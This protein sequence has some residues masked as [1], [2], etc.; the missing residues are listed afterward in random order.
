MSSVLRVSFGTL[1]ALM[2]FGAMLNARCSVKLV[3]GVLAQ[4][5]KY[6][7]LERMRTES[8]TGLITILRKESSLA[9]FLG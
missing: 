4:R 9:G 8:F 6:P 5:E 3:L 7:V 1:F 2:R